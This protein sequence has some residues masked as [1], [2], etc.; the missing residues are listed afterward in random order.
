MSNI[1]KGILVD[2]CTDKETVVDL[3]YE[4]KTHNGIRY[5]QLLNGVTGYE[6]FYIDDFDG[7]TREN[8]LALIR[9]NGWRPCIGTK[10]VYDELTISAEEMT[11]ALDGVV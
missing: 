9:K 4:I 1:I 5:F 3:M 2:C 11:K 10:G 7:K 8:T 6:S